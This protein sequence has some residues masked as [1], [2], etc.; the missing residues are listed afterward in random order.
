MDNP[1]TI[2]Q[3][4]D[5]RLDHEVSLVVYGRG[6]ICLGFDSLPVVR[7]PLKWL[8]LFRP[9]AIDLVL[10]K[11][12]RGNDAQDMADAA[13]LIRHDHITPAQLEEVFTQMKPI[14]LVELRDAF[15]KAKPT[16]LQFAQLNLKP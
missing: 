2:V 1:S 7:P 11:M 14:E 5:R 13:F 8:R 4:V 15:S 16:V 12:M 3:A 6:A 10:T 9:A